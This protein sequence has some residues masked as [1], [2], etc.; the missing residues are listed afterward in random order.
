MK[1]K[2]CSHNLH[3][4]LS[5]NCQPIPLLGMSDMTQT[6]TQRVKLTTRRTMGYSVDTI[7]RL[8]MLFK[9]YMTRNFFGVLSSS[10]CLKY[11]SEIKIRQK[12]CKTCFFPPSKHSNLPQKMSALSRDQIDTWCLSV[13]SCD[14]D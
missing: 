11:V 6:G 10:I 5:G 3:S 8:D 14:V 9:V 4:N 12:S 1:S 7:L 2:L 13:T